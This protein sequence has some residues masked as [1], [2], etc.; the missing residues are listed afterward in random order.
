MAK[1]SS[2]QTIPDTTCQETGKEV[3]VGKHGGI[4]VKNPTPSKY[5]RSV[6]ATCRYLGRRA[7]DMSRQKLTD[8][9]A[10]LSRGTTTS[11]PKVKEDPKDNFDWWEKY[12]KQLTFGFNGNVSKKSICEVC[13]EL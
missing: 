1:Q 9:A 12:L 5:G 2:D 10:M 6:G 13:S 7:K 11:C 3:I 8:V 4:Y